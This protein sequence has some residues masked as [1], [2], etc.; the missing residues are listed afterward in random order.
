MLV[1]RSSWLLPSKLLPPGV[2]GI[3]EAPATV[4]STHSPAAGG[5]VAGTEIQA[6]APEMNQVCVSPLEN[7]I[8]DLFLL[9]Y[10]RRFPEG[11]PACHGVTPL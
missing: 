5:V 6:R 9:L 4:V 11:S 2:L 10:G 7:L 3:C 8:S 1:G